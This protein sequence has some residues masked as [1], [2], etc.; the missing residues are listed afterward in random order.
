MVFI[1]RFPQ[2]ASVAGREMPWNWRARHT[3]LIVL[4]ERG[5]A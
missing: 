4:Q 1:V 5:F 2:E 3:M